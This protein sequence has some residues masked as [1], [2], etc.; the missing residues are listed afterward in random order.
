MKPTRLL[1]YV[2]VDLMVHN[3]QKHSKHFDIFEQ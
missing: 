1:F 2:F 3:I